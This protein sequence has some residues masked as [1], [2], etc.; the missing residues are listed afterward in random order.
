MDD[1]LKRIE[2]MENKMNQVSSYTKMLESML[3][4]FSAMEQT[5]EELWNYYENGEWMADY[6]LDEA[7]EVP[8]SM[9][10]GILSEDGLY[11][12]LGDFQDV[13]ERLINLK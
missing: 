1:T 5:V 8:E 3:D 10:R 4:S 13:R 11:N 12:V 2:Q 6:K 7:G 9:P